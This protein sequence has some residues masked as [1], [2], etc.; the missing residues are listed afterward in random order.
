MN[1][2]GGPTFT[3]AP[4]DNRPALFAG[5]P[6][7]VKATVTETP[8]GHLFLITRSNLPRL[9][10][11]TSECGT[12]FERFQMIMCALDVIT[13]NLVPPAGRCSSTVSSAEDRPGPS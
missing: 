9:V 3:A 1:L 8:S 13:P 2:A 11:K 12:R 5:R 4:G 7:V 6:A 10:S